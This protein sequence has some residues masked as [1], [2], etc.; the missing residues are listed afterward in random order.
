MAEVTVKELA[1]VVR[2][3]VDK[4]L[5]QLRDAGLDK[6]GESDSV[7]DQEKVQLLTHLQKGRG[8]VSRSTAADAGE[9]SS[10][11][12]YNSHCEAPTA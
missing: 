2:I 11:P 5:Q 8:T 10:A 9:D 3:P 1:E 4:L 6:Q 7:S 12:N